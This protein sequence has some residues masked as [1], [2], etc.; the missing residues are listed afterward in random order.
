[1]YDIYNDYRK[2][3]HDKQF[4]GTGCIPYK[5]V[6]AFTVFIRNLDA[7]H[8]V[9]T[10]KKLHYGKKDKQP[11]HQDGMNPNQTL[12]HPAIYLT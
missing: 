12:V 7:A 5:R 4:T 2:K 1:M 10:W 8:V 9:E 3:R 11:H 6:K